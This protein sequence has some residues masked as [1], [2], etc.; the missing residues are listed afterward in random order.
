MLLVSAVLI[1]HVLVSILAVLRPLVLTVAVLPLV[2]S[3]VVV[4]VLAVVHQR[5]SL[6]PVLSLLCVQH[7]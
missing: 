7:S 3:I 4:V 5:L 6:V 1:S 2:S